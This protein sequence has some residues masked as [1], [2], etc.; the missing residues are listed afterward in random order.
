VWHKCI[1]SKY[2]SS[3][4]WFKIVNLFY[5]LD[6]LFGTA[7]EIV[8]A[9]VSDNHKYKIIHRRK[10]MKKTALILA[11]AIFGVLGV[12]AQTAKVIGMK[13]AKSIALKQVK[14]KI[15]SAELEKEDGK[16]IYS[17]D[18]R[19]AKGET[20]EVRIDAFTGNIIDTKVETKA[21]EA[22]EKVSEAKEKGK[23][24]HWYSIG[25]KNK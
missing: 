13:K 14:G 8:S 21:D 16:D 12:S 10:I 5:L 11:I 20:N 18:I 23:K 19:T 24:K 9:S 7:I 1:I 6:F 2:V 17:F 25:K 4:N 15:E 22:K 3:R